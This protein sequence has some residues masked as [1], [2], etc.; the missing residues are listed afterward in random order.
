MFAELRALQT[1][2]YLLRFN[3][4]KKIKKGTQAKFSYQQARNNVANGR[5]YWVLN[6]NGHVQNKV[7]PF[8][9]EQN[10]PVN[11]ILCYCACWL[12]CQEAETAQTVQ[13][14]G[15]TVTNVY[16]HQ[17]RTWYMIRSRIGGNTTQSTTHIYNDL[18]TEINKLPVYSSSATSE[19]KKKNT[20]KAY[21]ER[22]YK[23]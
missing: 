21:E 4:K 11:R 6:H 16:L 18:S 23:K 17:N 10:K 14:I 2:F 5:T 22:E 12:T 3:K 19:K 1:G 13:K 20:V 7:P 8:I 15:N 9:K